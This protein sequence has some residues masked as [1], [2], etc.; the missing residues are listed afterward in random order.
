MKGSRVVVEAPAS[1][2]NLGCGFDIFAVALRTPKDRLTLRRAKSGVSVAVEGVELFT[3]RPKENVAGAVASAIMTDHG[4][5]G[6]ISLVLRKGVPVGAGLGSSAASSV[7]A[8]VGTNALFKLGISEKELIRYASIGERV[9]SGAAHYDNVTAS[10]VGGF[11]VVG[12]DYD[13]VK[14]EPPASMGLCFVT[15]KVKLPSEK[16]RFARS[17]LPKE[18]PLERMVEISR[19]ASLMVHGFAIGSVDEIGAAMTIS[20]VDERRAEMVP[21]LEEVRR[22]AASQGAAGLCM[23]GAGPSVLAVSARRSSG[24]VL[25]AMV[26]AFRLAGVESSGFVTGVG[27]GCRVLEG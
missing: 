10:L 22:A 19:A 24:R 20:L 5:R 9:A 25:R 2:A 21:G 16:T 17:L 26:R 14:M 8:A 12:R 7:A 13:H 18:V 4:V 11:V 23:S 3:E 27:Q 15:P 6:G 1:S